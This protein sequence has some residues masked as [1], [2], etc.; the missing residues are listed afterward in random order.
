MSR[1]WR[2]AVNCGD[3]KLLCKMSWRVGFKEVCLSR[4]S[5]FCSLFFL[6]H[7]RI[8]LDGTPFKVSLLSIDSPASFWCMHIYTGPRVIQPHRGKLHYPKIFDRG[9]CIHFEAM[10]NR[11]RQ[12]SELGF[13]RR[14]A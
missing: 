1:G 7:R 3:F 11:P 12:A 10:I 4:S 5:F 9:A 6:S 14:N 13:K 2:R 8:A